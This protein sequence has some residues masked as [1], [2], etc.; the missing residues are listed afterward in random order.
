MDSIACK[1]VHSDGQKRK[2]TTVTTVLSKVTH[3]VYG[4]EV[5]ATESPT[6]GRHGYVTEDLGIDHAQ[7]KD[8][9]QADDDQGRDANVT[10]RLV[11]EVL[12]VLV[13][14]EQPRQTQRLG[15]QP[16]P[17]SSGKGTHLTTDPHLKYD[18]A[19]WRF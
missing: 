5:T 13:K 8:N 2:L 10:Q 15:R 11:E 3:V 19:V 14:A 4:A 6:L 9:D 16:Q 12:D 7:E 18:K 17:P 1:R